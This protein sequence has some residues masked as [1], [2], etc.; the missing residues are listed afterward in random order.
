MKMENKIVCAKDSAIIE[1]INVKTGQMV[2]TTTALL[3]FK[4]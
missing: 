3:T 2:D 4:E 1:S